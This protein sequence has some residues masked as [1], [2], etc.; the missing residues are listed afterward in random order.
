MQPLRLSGGLFKR[1]SMFRFKW[2]N[3]TLAHGLIMRLPMAVRSHGT[4]LA[5]PIFYLVSSS[6]S[7]VVF[8][9]IKKNFVYR[10]WHPDLWCQPARTVQPSCVLVFQVR[11]FPITVKPSENTTSLQIYPFSDGICHFLLPLIFSLGG[12]RR[13]WHQN[14]KCDQGF[15]NKPIFSILQFLLVF[16]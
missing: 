4:S 9:S 3:W 15:G 11:N 5:R 7:L 8:C 6:R 12:E 14:R 13:G 16:R 2:R 1:S 10:C